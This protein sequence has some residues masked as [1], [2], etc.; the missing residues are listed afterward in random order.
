[1][2]VEFINE[3]G[4]RVKLS[5]VATEETLRKLVKILEK[6]Q[7]GSSRSNAFRGASDQSLNNVSDAIK[8]FRKELYAG[9]KDVRDFNKEINESSKSFAN[10]VQNAARFFDKAGAAVVKFGASQL[11]ASF[12]LK[13]YGEVISKAAGG[14]GET[15]KSF[16]GAVVNHTSN[17]VKTFN[18]LSNS[19]T[20]FTGN[21][22]DIERAAASSYLSL[23]KFS[24]ILEKNATN[25]A[26]YG[27]AATEGA[28]N[29]IQYNH[30]F[31]KHR[32]HML[33]LGIET[34]ERSEISANYYALQR[35][36]IDFQTL[37][38]EKQASAAV[39][40]AEELT[41]LS[42]LTGVSRKE[43]AE[44]M[45]RDRVA[46]D[47]E[48]LYGQLGHDE[49]STTRASVTAFQS[50]LGDDV[51]MKDL[52]AQGLRGINVASTKEGNLALLDPEG[53]AWNDL[54]L[55]ARMGEE[56]T[57]EKILDT[58][59]RYGVDFGKAL[60]QNAQIRD[61]SGHVEYAKLQSG[62][63]LRKQVISE[64]QQ[65]NRDGTLNQYIERR[66]DPTTDNVLKT[67]AATEDAYQYTRNL[68]NDLV[69]GTVNLI[70]NLFPK[71]KEEI[72]K[73]LTE[74][75]LKIAS[76]AAVGAMSGFTESLKRLSNFID[77][78]FLTDSGKTT[79]VLKKVGETFPKLTSGI[80]SVT[81][82]MAGFTKWVGRISAPIAGG[83]E[84]WNTW[85]TSE[86]TDS[87]LKRGIEASVTGASYGAGAFG[88]A[89][90][91]AKA[92]AFLGA[93]GGPIAPITI[94]LG[95][96]G[97]GVA[98]AWYGG[99]YAGELGKA[100]INAVMPPTKETQFRPRPTGFADGGII[101]QPT[102]AMIGEGKNDEAV[103]P[104]KN[105]RNVPVELNSSIN[106]DLIKT[107]EKQI[108]MQKMMND[109]S[110]M[111]LT[112]L[113]NLNR[114]TIKMYR[115]AQ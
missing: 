90:G 32:D 89:F 67:V 106:D 55:R 100:G 27:G 83:L 81:D 101:R 52:F 45:A 10:S 63:D 7:P 99:K 66:L 22:F 70:G 102:L 36:N 1:M 46:P 18:S 34:E 31:Q 38:T 69:E 109:T 6:I 37:S 115:E 80:V 47:L 3:D 59:E 14:F 53:R 2:A 58:M 113:K 41:K 24:S 82:K 72:D 51:G 42:A 16:S 54:G 88:G 26:I 5:G 65:A 86:H 105:D 62:W 76:T 61:L 78:K 73:I 97:G 96:I 60:K 12:D 112:E 108:S 103:I 28:K 71:M 11:G 95:A 107:I 44:K 84:G 93:F 33:K 110:T 48:I 20:L 64:M 98:G 94:P 39:V 49:N 43:L 50:L 111:M 35:H 68:G 23:E 85:K 9:A 30:E 19:G 92:G 15:A 57:H 91:G 25:F 29:F 104:L 114:Q 17:L 75:P 4:N 77:Q 56:I 40:F 79:G 8:N 87:N 21:L 74:S 13:T